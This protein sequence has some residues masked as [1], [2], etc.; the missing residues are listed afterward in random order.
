[1][2]YFEYLR[3]PSIGADLLKIL[4][5]GIAAGPYGFG[6]AQVNFPG[7]FHRSLISGAYNGHVPGVSRRALLA[8]EAKGMVQM[9]TT[10]TKLSE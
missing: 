8:S 1:V 5:A 6:C 2:D 4:R 7:P 3:T 9:N 10:I